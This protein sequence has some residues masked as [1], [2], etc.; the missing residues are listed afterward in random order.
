MPER[1]I[2]YEKPTCTKCREVKQLL[3]D[4]DLEFQTVNYFEQPLTADQLKQLL[5]AAGLKPADAL[6]TNEP[7]YREFV[8][9]RNLDDDQLIRVMAD[10]PELIQRPFVVRGDKAVLARPSAELEKLGL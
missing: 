7:S 1:I 9:G 4:Q 10:H 6:R 5:R 2:V 3:T 8:A